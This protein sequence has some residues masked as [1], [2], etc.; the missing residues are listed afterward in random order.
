MNYKYLFYSKK[1]GKI[2]YICP[3]LC[4]TEQALFFANSLIERI[5]LFAKELNINKDKIFF[6][7]ITISQRYK[8]HYCFFAETDN[9]NI[10]AFVLE[11][12]TMEKFIKA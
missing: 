11:N 4:H 9:I 7:E 1:D 3:T 2:F 12:Q 8:K 10:N 6:Y 5:E